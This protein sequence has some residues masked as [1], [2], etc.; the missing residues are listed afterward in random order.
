MSQGTQ[1]IRDLR[2][3]TP[4]GFRGLPV[5][6]PAPCG[7]ECNACREACPTGA[8]SLDP[9]RLDLGR[10]VFCQ[11]CVDACPDRKIHFTPEPKMG[12]CQRDDLVVREGGAEMIRVRAS[13]AFSRLFGRSL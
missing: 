11:A 3:A 8:I 7:P 13:A 12:A 4:T 10:C 1:Y 9:L 6:G 5:L 2:R